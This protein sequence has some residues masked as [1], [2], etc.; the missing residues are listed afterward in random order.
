MVNSWDFHGISPKNDDFMGLNWDFTGFF[1]IKNG[2]LTW[3]ILC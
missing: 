2:D 1:P 3:L